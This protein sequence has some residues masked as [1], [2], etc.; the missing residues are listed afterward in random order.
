VSQMGGGSRRAGRVAFMVM[1]AV[2]EPGERIEALAQCRYL[3][4]DA[5]LAVT[6]D[7]VL[8]VNSREWDPDIES[9]S[10]SPDLTVQ[11]WQDQRSACLVFSHDGTTAV[12]DRISDM[13]AAKVVADLV[14]SRVG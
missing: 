13:A 6:P 8:I 7:R 5:A 11:G 3:G 9:I 12:V 1:A 4:A 14:R 2:L 10:F